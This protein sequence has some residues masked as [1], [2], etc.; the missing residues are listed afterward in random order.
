[1]RKLGRQVLKGM[2]TLF[3][4][5]WFMPHNDQREARILIRITGGTSENAAARAPA[6]R[7]VLL[8]ASIR[9]KR[10]P[11]RAGAVQEYI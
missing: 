9:K 10:C 3:S 5:T 6:R 4:G 11:G 2:P 1:A 7:L 8:D